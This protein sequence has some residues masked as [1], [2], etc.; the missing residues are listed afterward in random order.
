MRPIAV[1]IQDLVMMLA[2]RQAIPDES[3]SPLFDNILVDLERLDNERDE[4]KED[5]HYAHGVA[6]LAI[7]HRDA[8]EAIL[9]DVRAD[10]VE[11]LALIDKSQAGNL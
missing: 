9:S 1:Q 6:K 3:W 10:L 4:A 2:R 7:K 5:A 11:I 8:A